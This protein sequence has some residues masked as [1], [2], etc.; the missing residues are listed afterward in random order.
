MKWLATCLACLLLT[1][2]VA[3]QDQTAHKRNLTR[4][5]AKWMA[6]KPA[7]YEFTL[8]YQT[9][10]SGPLLAS[11]RVSG[12]KST[13]L[14]PSLGKWDGFLEQHNTID[15]VF[16]D[17]ERLS[18]N[19]YAQVRFTF[20]DDF[21]YPSLGFFYSE[22]GFDTQF[23]VVGFRPI[24]SANVAE[25]PFMMLERSA[26]HS[27]TTG[28]PAYS[29]AVWGDGTVVYDGAAGPVARG[30]RTHR[31]ASAQIS[32]L[33]NAFATARFFE[34]EPNYNSK[35]GRTKDGVEIVTIVD[36]YSDV[37]VTA[38]IGSQRHSVHGNAF[39]PPEL[40]TLE[41]HIEELSGATLYFHWRRKLPLSR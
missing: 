20:N 10:Y 5:R 4:Q 14:M 11:F 36:H 7:S 34:L 41:N 6:R 18:G 38:R 25:A 27:F 3:G 8:L 19:D 1:T 35:L 28:T 9:T 39:A 31:I 24:A 13:A 32:A 21:G 37:R 40:V 16:D 2:P 15:L 26:S 29:V 33:L 17:L 12:A 23:E 30:R 22:R